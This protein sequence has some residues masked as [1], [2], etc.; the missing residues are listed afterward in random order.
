M[1]IFH[2]SW[3]F[4]SFARKK[5]G[6]AAER[7]YFPRDRRAFRGSRQWWI[8]GDVDNEIKTSGKKKGGPARNRR[9]ESSEQ[10]ANDAGL[11][12]HFVTEKV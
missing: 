3:D 2:S 9:I 6:E 5:K 10:S 7:R 4:A 11:G 1:W 8:V 12:R